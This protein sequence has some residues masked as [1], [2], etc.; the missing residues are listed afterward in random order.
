MVLGLTLIFI[1]LK[2]VVEMTYI[3]FKTKNNPNLHP[4]E[5]I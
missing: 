3:S 2:G 1:E 5:C 4:K